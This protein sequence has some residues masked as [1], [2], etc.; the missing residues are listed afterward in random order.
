L[1]PQVW[2]IF[3]YFNNDAF[4]IFVATLLAW[5]V[6]DPASGFNRFLAGDGSRR[7]GPAL[8]DSSCSRHSWRFRKKNFLTVL[9]LLPA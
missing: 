2:Y 8:S 7:A 1:S 6:V 9:A 4:P 5:Q 3:S